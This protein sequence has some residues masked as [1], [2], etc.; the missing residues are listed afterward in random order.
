MMPIDSA[1][2]VDSRT[3]QPPRNAALIHAVGSIRKGRTLSFGP[4]TVLSVQC[5]PGFVS[6]VSR[7]RIQVSQILEL[8]L[9]TMIEQ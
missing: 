6:V 3:H 9:L 5:L 4:G 1:S 8:S 2:N 7:L